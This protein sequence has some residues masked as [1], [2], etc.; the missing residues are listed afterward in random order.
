MNGGNLWEK[1]NDETDAFYV[2]IFKR[3][4]HMLN[5]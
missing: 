1:E 3:R 4:Y 5:N 2:E